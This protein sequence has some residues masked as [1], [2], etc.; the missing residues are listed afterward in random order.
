MNY[1]N[2]VAGLIALFIAL[3]L[4]MTFTFFFYLVGFKVSNFNDD[5]EKQN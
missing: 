3:P 5:S 4:P 2:Q 1:P